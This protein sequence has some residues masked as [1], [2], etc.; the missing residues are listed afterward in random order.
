MTE[1]PRRK[2]Q[3]D[4]ND[5]KNEADP[6][7]LLSL[8]IWQSMSTPIAKT[9]AR[10]GD[11]RASDYQIPDL[12]VNAMGMKAISAQ[13]CLVYTG[14]NH[15][16]LNTQ[17]FSGQDLDSSAY[18][19]LFDGKRVAEA[20]W[21]KSADQRYIMRPHADKSWHG[22]SS[23]TN[24][25]ARSFSVKHIRRQNG[26]LET[27]YDDGRA[28]KIADTN[29][30]KWI[31]SSGVRPSDYFVLMKSA[32]NSIHTAIEKSIDG[33]SI[34]YLGFSNS[35]KICSARKNL[36]DLFKDRNSDEQSKYKLQADM[37][38]FESKRLAQME[39]NFQSG[40]LSAGA[41]R[42][43][44]EREIIGT[45]KQAGRLLETATF[46]ADRHPDKSL[47]PFRMSAA[48]AEQIISHA[49]RPTEIDQGL[50]P[51]C[52]VA[53]LEVRTYSRHPSAAARMVADFA[54]NLSY[55]SS[56][57]KIGVPVDR[58]SILS[59]QDSAHFVPRESQR[60]IASQI[61]QVGAYNLMYRI[62][63]PNLVFK[64]EEVSAKAPSGDHVYDAFGK[65]KSDSN[66][67]NVNWLLDA[68]DE[69]TSDG[70]IAAGNA[71]SGIT[72]N[73]E[74]SGRDARAPGSSPWI[75]GQ[76]WYRD[77]KNN[78]RTVLVNNK[79][80]LERVLEETQK[81]GNFPVVLIVDTR[82]Q[83]LPQ[84]SSQKDGNARGG[85]HVIS[86]FGYEKGSVGRQSTV[87]L[88]NE[89]GA[90]DDR[91]GKSAISV[92]QA[93]DMMNNPNDKLAGFFRSLSKLP[94]IFK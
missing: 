87:E 19:R 6:A 91:L 27:R 69:I 17:T 65:V 90:D 36:L 80:D 3:I 67:N 78:D 52:S 93:F 79:E 48:C 49:A 42:A 30:V 59:H 63:A 54:T 29:G 55:S 37:M 74:Q 24:D 56:K 5:Y 81:R 28:L 7:E 82:N 77:K 22:E 83:S 4:L 9:P 92:E 16:I 68:Y 11:K 60:G 2:G 73:S 66:T 53:T 33:K 25:G 46:I 14:N 38:Y 12:Q 76:S 40:G 20:H 85:S 61:F 15:R 72:G 47:S 35:E 51:S 71:G 64:Q 10:A 26:N 70:N 21:G 89:W 58:E 75:I 8:R 18:I 84:A 34:E 86:I 32:D 88:D 50:H 45:Y 44:A 62:G 1:I 94:Y 13:E 39:R 23:Y 41:A 57:S 43:N 31:C